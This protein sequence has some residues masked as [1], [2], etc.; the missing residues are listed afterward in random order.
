MAISAS[1]IVRTEKAGQ[2]E[3]SISPVVARHREA[4]LAHY[5]K[6]I[7]RIKEDLSVDAGGE[8]E[9]ETGVNC[10]PLGLLFGG[11]VGE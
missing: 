5:G 6:A 10:L 9:P 11:H 1:R 7:R 4:A 8:R 3:M 2:I